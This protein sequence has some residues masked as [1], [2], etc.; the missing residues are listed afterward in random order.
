[1]IGK[2]EDTIM[3]Q[4]GILRRNDKRDSS[5]FLFFLLSVVKCVLVGS[6]GFVKV[7]YKEYIIKYKTRTEK[8]HTVL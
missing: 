5:Y 2:E 3:I 6:P 1:M 8:A 4:K 7:Q